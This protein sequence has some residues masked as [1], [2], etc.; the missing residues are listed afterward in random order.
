MPPVFLCAFA[1]HPKTFGLSSQAATPTHHFLKQTLFTLLEFIDRKGRCEIVYRG[2]FS[3][4]ETHRGGGA[5][6]FSA[7]SGLFACGTETRRGLNN[8]G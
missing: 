7:N 3:Q 6:L 4:D 5:R 8:N 1:A 2:A